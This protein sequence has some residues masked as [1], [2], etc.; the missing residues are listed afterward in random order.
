MTN[1][2]KMC[3]GVDIHA[4]VSVESGVPLNVESVTEMN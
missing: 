3:L 2:A 4:L 1:P